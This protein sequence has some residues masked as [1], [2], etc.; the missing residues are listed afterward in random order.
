MSEELKPCPFCGGGE[1][2][3]KENGAFWLGTRYS[4]PVSFS[5]QHWCIKTP[6]QP[7]SSNNYIERKGRTKQSAIDAW[8]L[9][10]NEGQH[11][12]RR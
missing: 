3:F 8:N 10:F 9:R 11:E 6:G 7:M 2:A 1:F 4:E 5:I 12:Q